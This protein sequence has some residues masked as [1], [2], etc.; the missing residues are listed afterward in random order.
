MT[1]RVKYFRKA[2]LESKTNILFFRSLSNFEITVIHLFDILK[3]IYY[4]C[5][6]YL[7]LY[8][9]SKCELGYN[10]LHT[11]YIISTH[12]IPI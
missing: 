6:H 4:F 7:N 3:L 9:T 12:K 5:L 10:F 8:L 2:F 1:F 11:S